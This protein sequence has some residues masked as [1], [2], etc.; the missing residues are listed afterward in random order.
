MLWES[1]PVPAAMWD[2]EDWEKE[3]PSQE[4]KRQGH[5]YGNR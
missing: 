5:F 4:D 3:A 1:C 2:S